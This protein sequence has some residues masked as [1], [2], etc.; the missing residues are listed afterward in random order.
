[1]R[2]REF[3]EAVASYGVRP[4]SKNDWWAD[5]LDLGRDGSGKWCSYDGWNVRVV[6]AYRLFS[7]VTGQPPRPLQAVRRA[8]LMLARY[9][10]GW[11]M[12]RRR[13]VTHLTQPTA[14]VFVDG[15]VLV[16]VPMW[17]H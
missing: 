3:N 12:V 7:Q 1:M 17:R 2:L 10:H 8:V 13:W 9:E 11:V 4:A 14:D 6:V 5:L 15:A 16:K